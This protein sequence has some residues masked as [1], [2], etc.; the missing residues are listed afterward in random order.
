MFNNA[1]NISR[2]RFYFLLLF[3]VSISFSSVYSL[4]QSKID[5][6]KA[7]IE[8]YKKENN[9]AEE[10]KY[11]NKIAFLY[12]N[13][14][15]LRDA[16][17]YFEQSISINEEIGNK[18]ALRAIY[19]NLGLISLDLEEYQ[20]SI[21]Y[22]EKSLK[23]NESLKKKDAIASDLINIASALHELG[24]YSESNHKTSRALEI[25]KELNNLDLIKNCY[26]QLAN[27]YKELLEY[28]KNM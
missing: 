5:E 11:L 10:A 15:A 25:G 13:I 6:Y 8:Q 17:N 7:M 16:K 27:N 2:Y 18:N 20:N 19:D 1:Y 3:I 28:L 23:I 24:Y 14:D 9:K 26:N 21:N 12:W 22:F 4:D